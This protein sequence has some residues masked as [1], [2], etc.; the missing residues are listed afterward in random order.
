MNTFMT[1]MLTWMF[2]THRVALG[3]ASCVFYFPT[4][5]KIT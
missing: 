2:E 1:I 5:G 3:G 4:L